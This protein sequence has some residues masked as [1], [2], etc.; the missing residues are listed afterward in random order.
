MRA[1]ETFPWSSQFVATADNN[2]PDTRRSSSAM[3]LAVNKTRVFIPLLTL[4]VLGA[5]SSMTGCALFRDF[6]EP[7]EEE[8]DQIFLG[9]CSREAV[10]DD[11]EDDDHRVLLHAD[12][13]GYMFTFVDNSG[14]TVSPPP[15]S[16]AG[17]Y[18]ELSGANG[19]MYGGRFHGDMGSGGTVYAGYGMNLSEPRMPYDA[20]KY[21]GITLFARR[22]PDSSAKVRL[23]L[24]D[25]QTDP[26]GGI[27][28]E[29]FNAFGKD[30]EL[31][32][33]WKQ[34]VVMFDEM[35]QEDGWG[36][37]RPSALDTSA[38]FAIQFQVSSPGAHY[39]MW[40][41]DISFFGCQGE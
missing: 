13:G 1:A 2:A 6:V 10:I 4:V 27:C 29:C 36:S 8:Q 20:S 38:L 9:G 33:E 37:P 21:T 39:D 3:T 15:G 12:R 34:Q 32:T 40:V 7:L 30:L 5:T 19:S 22:A 26:A 16:Q 35:T 24:L 14:S 18:Y 28:T 11:G 41:D 17:A 25:A 31:E 23:K